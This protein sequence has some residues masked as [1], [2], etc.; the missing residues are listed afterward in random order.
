MITAWLIV[1]FGLIAAGCGLLLLLS[2]WLNTDAEQAPQDTA[3][4]TATA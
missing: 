3:T 2:H 1:G 4:A